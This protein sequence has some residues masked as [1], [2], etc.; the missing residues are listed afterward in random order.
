MYVKK[1]D[2]EIDEELDKYIDEYL[3]AL[4]SDD[5]CLDCYADQLSAEINNSLGYSIDLEQVKEPKRYYLLSVW[6]K[7]KDI[8]MMFLT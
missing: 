7:N 8:R 3:N 5:N 6:K 2:F 1:F 4:N